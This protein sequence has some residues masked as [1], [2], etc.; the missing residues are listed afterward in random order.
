MSSLPVVQ[1]QAVDYLDQ[2]SALCLKDIIAPTMLQLRRVLERL[3][4]NQRGGPPALAPGPS[5]FDT[6]GMP[7]L[8]S[9]SPTHATATSPVML[10]PRVVSSPA[11]V[12]PPVAVDSRTMEGLLDFF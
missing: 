3:A 10:P 6:G 12:S 11:I 5:S 1:G 7:P 2:A 9:A 8:R 4:E